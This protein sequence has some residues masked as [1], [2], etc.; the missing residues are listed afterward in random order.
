MYGSQDPPVYPT[1][2]I[3]VSA[4]VGPNTVTKL[5][6]KISLRGIKPCGRI[7]YIIRD[8]YNGG[9]HLAI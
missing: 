7:M 6:Y 9:K 1:I 3:T 2:L 8:L 4:E 5:N